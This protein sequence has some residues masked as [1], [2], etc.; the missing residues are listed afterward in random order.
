MLEYV[1]KKNG[2]EYTIEYF[3]AMNRVTIVANIYSGHRQP[4]TSTQKGVEGHLLVKN[5]PAKDLE[6]VKEYI[7]KKI[8]REKVVSKDQTRMEDF[9]VHRL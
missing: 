7:S 2:K 4:R 1:Q 8:C 3:K 6:S 5:L 9:Y